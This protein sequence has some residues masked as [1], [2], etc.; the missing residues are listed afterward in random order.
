MKPMKRGFKLWVRSDM[1]GYISKL[2]VY[3][4]KGTGSVAGFGLGENVILN[5]IEDLKGGNHQV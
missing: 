2:D 5:L 4:G 3:Q 1:D